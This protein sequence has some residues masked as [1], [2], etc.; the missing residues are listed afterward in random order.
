MFNLRNGNVLES[1]ENLKSALEEYK[2]FMS[3]E[4]YSYLKSLIA[5]EV[6]A[7]DSKTLDEKRDVLKRIDLYKKI[8][9]YNICMR[10]RSLLISNG[11]GINFSTVENF[12][13][14]VEYEIYGNVNGRSFPVFGFDI[15]LDNPFY[16]GDADIYLTKVNELARKEEIERLTREIAREEKKDNPYA[17]RHDGIIRYNEENASRWEASRTAKIKRMQ[18]SLNGLINFSGLDKKEEEIMLSQNRL[19]KLLLSDMHLEEEDFEPI[20][21]EGMKRTLTKKYPEMSIRSNINNI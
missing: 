8:A 5:L 16:I 14:P 15:E 20:Q 21:G 13:H 3:N 6:S 9:I 12:V 11:E 4:A 7:L 17:R 18:K 1:E 2:W 19:T 10:S